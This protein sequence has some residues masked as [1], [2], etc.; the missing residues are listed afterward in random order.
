MERCCFI[1]PPETL[2]ILEAND[3]DQIYQNQEEQDRAEREIVKKEID[4]WMNEVYPNVADKLLYGNFNQDFHGMDARTYVEKHRDQ[5][6]KFYPSQLITSPGARVRI[7]IKEERNEEEVAV[8][9]PSLYLIG[10]LPEEEE[11]VPKKQHQPT[12]P[13]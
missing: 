1:P 7:R 6:G 3:F 2:P 11:Q 12:S 10:L 13:S 8:I 4:E 9:Y 5:Q